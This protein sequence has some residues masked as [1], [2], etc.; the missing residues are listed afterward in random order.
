MALDTC[1]AVAATAITTSAKGV[2]AP[3]VQHVPTGADA[4]MR[5]LEHS[6][7]VSCACAQCRSPPPFLLRMARDWMQWRPDTEDPAQPWPQGNWRP[8]DYG[9]AEV[10]AITAPVREAG[11]LV[12]Q[13][14]DVLA[15]PP[16]RGVAAL[17]SSVPP[18][19]VGCDDGPL[20]QTPQTALL[21]LFMALGEGFG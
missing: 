1:I 16:C 19:R 13:V 8:R 6:A 5:S 4:L 11:H 10:A 21:A 14:H 17:D 20:A 18:G 3:M 12:F 15:G 2:A 9:L 7:A